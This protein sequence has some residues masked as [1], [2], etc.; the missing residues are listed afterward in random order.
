[1]GINKY[2]QKEMKY[3][4]QHLVQTLTLLSFAQ[5]LLHPLFFD[6]K[7]ETEMYTICLLKGDTQEAVW[8]FGLIHTESLQIHRM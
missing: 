2:L 4:Y 3:N 6:F 1:M 5:T 7:I 8:H